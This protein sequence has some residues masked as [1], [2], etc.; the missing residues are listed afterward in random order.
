MHNLAIRILCGKWACALLLFIV[1]SP[2]GLAVGGTLATTPLRSLSALLPSGEGKILVLKYCVTCHGP[3]VLRKRL[4]ERRQWQTKDWED[5]VFEMNESWAA[6]IA[7]EEIDPIVQYLSAAFGPEASE[8]AKLNQLKMS[9]QGVQLK[10][11]VLDKCT[12][13][14]APGITAVRLKS[15]V[16]LPAAGWK[17][18]LIRMQGYG[19]SL[20]DAEIRQLS[21]SLASSFGSSSKETTE[22]IGQL[23]S[24]LPAGDG[25]DSIV[26]Q[27]LSCH[28]VSDFRRQLS[29]HPTKDEYYWDRVVRRMKEQWD[30]PLLEGDI[31]TITGYLKSHF[32]K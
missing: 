5:L 10:Q 15:R 19:A 26:A 2:T 17:K 29:D 7:R 6:S 13:C 24:S 31:E 30:A 14:H 28:D 20:T 1:V 9:L 22:P 21:E 18:V 8:S 3:Q 12:A 27:C 11:L 23:Y 25:R 32:G 16:G 4:E